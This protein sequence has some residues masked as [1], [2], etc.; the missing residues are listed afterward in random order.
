[1]TSTILSCEEARKR[2]LQ[3]TEPVGTEM[4]QLSDCLG[5]ILAEDIRAAADVP[6][7]PRS[8]FDGYAFRA[9]DTSSA[10]PETPVTLHILEEV[11]AGKVPETRLTEGT[12]V[13]ILTGAMLPEGADSVEMF[14][15][16]EF[17]ETSVT[18][19][20]PGRP[21]NNVVPR[22]EDAVRGQLL[23]AKGT[24]IDPGLMGVFASQG[25]RE[26]PVFRI[27][28]VGA[29][30]T[31]TEV[32][33]LGS[34]LPRGKIYN[35]NRA[36]FEGELRKL[37]VRPVRVGIARD[38]VREIRELLELALDTCDAVLLTGGVS[39][40]AYDLTGRAILEAGGEPLFSGV[41]M[42][43]GKA[44]FYAVRDGK[45]ICALSG[46]PASAMTNYHAVAKAGLKRLCGWNQG[47]CFPA[48]IRVALKEDFPKKSKNERWVR[49]R[50]DLS[51][52]TVRI[53]VPKQQKNSALSSTVGCDVMAVI[54]AGSGPLP[55]GTVL[56]G[57]LMN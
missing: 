53:D 33:E 51:D 48:E 52:G 49:G 32:V 35:S 39:V 44:C 24:K 50:L 47:D 40:G 22:G 57:Y 6:D 41:A 46:N 13:R 1:M 42:K 54:P 30:S 17:T 4:I 38:S 2:F 11:P 26:I 43:P 20:H 29:I 45:M 9:A 21:G 18:L 5:R 56:Q 16:T 28:K 36:L 8:A 27:P 12:A 14:E 7:W 55:A 31:G 19:F 23:A 3:F 15:K 34:V 37:G 10:S 25:L